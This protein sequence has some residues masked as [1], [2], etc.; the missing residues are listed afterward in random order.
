MLGFQMSN[1]FCASCRSF[2]FIM[3]CAQCSCM[4][5]L[6]LSIYLKALFQI[7][8]EHYIIL[9][10]YCHN[11]L[12]IFLGPHR[13]N[14]ACETK[15]LGPPQ[16]KNQGCP[17][18]WSHRLNQ[19]TRGVQAIWSH[20]INL[21]CGVSWRPDEWPPALG[22]QLVKTVALQ[23]RAWKPLLLTPFPPLSPPTLLLPLLSLPAVTED[24]TYVVS[25]VGEGAKWP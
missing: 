22:Q 5:I 14:S 4:V 8:R 11:I 19:K 2:L 17:S 6:F 21:A 13:P 9:A 12:M 16:S 18:L 10:Y 15:W 3:K 25:A 24:P 23:P 1:D 7:Q 20:R